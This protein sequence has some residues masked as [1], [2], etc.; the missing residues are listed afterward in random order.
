MAKADKKAKDAPKEK[1]AKAEAE[2]FKYGV[3]DV[4]KAL[5]VKE[6]SAR[7]QLRNHKVKK[8]G[9]SYGWNS[10]DELQGVIEKIRPAKEEKPAKAAK[11]SK[12]S[13]D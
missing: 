12:K 2:T 6:A 1:P 4:A 9:K 10:K 8:A 3:A 13:D 5:G 7:V 11:K